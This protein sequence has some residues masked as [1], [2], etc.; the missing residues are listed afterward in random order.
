MAHLS[1]N[2]APLKRNEVNSS[3]VSVNP[4]RPNL[5]F[6][7]YPYFDTVESIPNKEQL[8]MELNDFLSRCAEGSTIAIL[9]SPVMAADFSSILTKNVSYKLWIAIKNRSHGQ[10]NGSLVQ[11]HCALLILTK[12]KS[13]LRHTKTRISYTYC[14]ACDRTTKDYGGKKHLFHEFGTLMSDV[15]R[16]IEM[17]FTS[18][19]PEE[20]IQRLQDLFGLSEYSSI[21]IYD[22]RGYYEDNSGEMTYKCFGSMSNDFEE[23]S[24]LINGDCLQV[25]QD[26]PDNCVDFCFADPPYNLNKKYESWDDGLDITEYFD[27]CDEWLTQLARV[28]KPGRTLAVLNIPQWSIRYF[29]QLTRL[30]D[31][32]DW[33]VWEA[34]GMPV[35]MIMPSHYTILCFSKGRPRPLPGLIRTHHSH[36]EKESLETLRETYCTRIS[37]SRKRRLSG[38]NDK[39]VVSNLWWDIHRLKHNSRRVDHPCQ[40]PP[41]LMSRLISLFTNK[42]EVVLDPFNG[43]GTTTLVAEQ[44]ERKYVGIEISDYYHDLAVDRHEEISLG[45]DPFRKRDDTGPKAKNSPVKRLKKRKYRVTKKRLQLEIKRIASQLGHIPTREEAAKISK[46]PLEYYD[47][48]FINWGEVTAA[49]RTTGMTEFRTDKSKAR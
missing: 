28:L 21:N 43:V 7:I 48:Y 46:Y 35:R 47:D 49:A 29:K 19:K 26:V 42:G 18:D 12:Y 27:W 45:L 9:C 37:C 3:I 31:Y 14:P 34:M 33:I 2:V 32:Q 38:I 10:R 22:Q 4:T 40:L 36:L 1:E 13:A 17:D 30:L 11:R 8:Y 25:L 23:P 20:V 24:K 41:A 6:V 15:W 39:E 5:E 44:L 16:D